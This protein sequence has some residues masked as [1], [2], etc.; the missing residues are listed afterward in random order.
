MTPTIPRLRQFGRPLTCP[1]PCL[2]TSKQDASCCFGF[3]F[4]LLKALVGAGRFLPG[5]QKQSTIRGLMS[6]NGV[7][8]SWGSGMFNL[9][10]RKLE[11]E[12]VRDDRPRASA[13]A[14]LANAVVAWC[15]RLTNPKP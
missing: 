4:V 12:R 2:M 10:Q 5:W 11:G 6:G 15:P 9:K 8:I 1:C 14:L 13:S 3:L 7:F